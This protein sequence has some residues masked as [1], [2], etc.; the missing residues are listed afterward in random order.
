MSKEKLA[1]RTKV[2]ADGGVM[3]G[4]FPAAAA[5]VMVTDLETSTNRGLLAVKITLK[6]PDSVGVPEIT[7]VAGLTDRPAG[8]PEAENSVAPLLAVIVYPA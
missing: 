5:T 7:P 1:V 4:G 6:A 3:T 8:R 2:W